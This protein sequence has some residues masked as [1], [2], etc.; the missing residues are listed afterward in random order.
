MQSRNAPL[1]IALFAIRFIIMTVAPEKPD[2]NLLNDIF[3]RPNPVGAGWGNY[4]DFRGVSVV[5]GN[6]FIDKAPDKTDDL[7]PA[8]DSRHRL[9]V[10][11]AS[12]DGS[13]RIESCVGREKTSPGC[14][15]LGVHEAKIPTFQNLDCLNVVHLDFPGL[16]L[17]SPITTLSFLPRVT[18]HAGMAVLPAHSCAEHRAPSAMLELS[19]PILYTQIPLR[20]GLGL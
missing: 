13:I 1:T 10:C 4:F 14:P 7:V 15:V 6:A 8:P 5:D 20:Q 12:R 9:G 17:G 16:R 3:H 19:E 18:L 2:S 11:A